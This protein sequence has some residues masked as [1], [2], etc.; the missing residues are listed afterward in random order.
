MPESALLSL[1]VPNPWR[2]LP[3]KS[4]Y[5]L[6]TDLGLLR[7]FNQGAK[8]EYR[9]DTSLFPEPFFGSL[10]APV[11]VLNLNPG[12]SPDDAR[13]HSDPV[14][15][16]MARQSLEHKLNPYPFLHLQPN[17]D[18]PGGRWWQQRTRELA[19]DV[20][21][22]VVAR[23]LACIQFVPY[24]SPKFSRSSPRF[25]SQDYSFYLV[26]RAMACG[27][28]IVIMRSVRLWL[29][30]VPELATY[31][32]LHQGSNPRTPFLSR[33]NLLASYDIIAER[34]RSAAHR[35]P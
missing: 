15:K 27:A 1:T 22:H 18:T 20:G 13:V 8:D 35:I 25:P 3:K 30:A 17:G 16:R 6:K 23:Q 28:D 31:E 19:A 21:F 10:D 5:V 29:D 7:N 9:Y 26:R 33:G 14:F 24:H 12:W 34:M 11:V 32:R 2:F 4:P